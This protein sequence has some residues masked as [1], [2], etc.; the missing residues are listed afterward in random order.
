MGAGRVLAEQPAGQRAERE[1]R[2]HGERRAPPARPLAGGQRQLA[3]PGAAH[4]E[5]DAADHALGEPGR[6]TAGQRVTRR[7][8]GQRRQRRQDD[9]GDGDPAAAEPVRQRAGEQQGGDEAGRVAAEQGREHLGRQVQPLLVDEQQRVGTFVPAA[10]ANRANTARF[11]IT[12]RPYG[13]A[14]DAIGDAW[15]ARAFGA[16]RGKIRGGQGRDVGRAG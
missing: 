2:R 4:A 12:G 6:E 8:E 10:T 14:R 7:G 16:R 13:P 11:Q 5:D 15:A 9:A 3:D 1:A